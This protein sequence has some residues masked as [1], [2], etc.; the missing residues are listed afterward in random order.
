MARQLHICICVCALSRHGPAHVDAYS[1]YTHRQIKTAV[2]ITLL[3]S[4]GAPVIIFIIII[5][6]LFLLLLLYY[7]MGT[8][9]PST[10]FPPAPIERERYCRPHVQTGNN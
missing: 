4:R 10:P 2:L 9:A 3:R 1:A 7:N 6:L 8:L 5:I